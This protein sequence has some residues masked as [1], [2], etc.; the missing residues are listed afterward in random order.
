MRLTLQEALKRENNN[1]NI[2]RL[3]ASIAVIFGH[4]WAVFY[5]NGNAEPV[6]EIL[7]VDFSASL[8]V[9]AFFFLSGIFI[10]SSFDNSKS[11]IRF[12]LMRIFRIYPGLIICILIT[13]FLVGPKFST[14]STPAYFTDTQ[15]WKYLFKNMI[16]LRFEPT[17]TGIFTNNKYSNS[18]NASLWSL[19]L[20]IKCYLLVFIIGISGLRKKKFANLLVF[21]GLICI[22][23]FNPDIVLDSFKPLL[24]FSLGMTTYSFKN[25]IAIDLR[26]WIGMVVL[27]IVAFFV[28]ATL[29][30]DLFYVTF[31]YSILVAGTSVIAKGIK[32]PGDF[33]Y[34]IYIYGFLV[35]QITA[36]F[37]PEIT[38]YYS[39]LITMPISCL[40]GALSWYLIES[41][42]MDSGK[43][44]S[45]LNL[46]S[47][48]P[49]SAN[50]SS[51]N[52]I[53]PLL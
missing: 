25:N 47:R 10:T 4:S 7:K 50:V 24:F 42:A 32:L 36:H 14:L 12:V 13:V 22:Y 46:W 41:P 52:H 29:F 16:M 45:K 30:L 40:I 17:L 1:F 43:R 31:A 3:S 6:K 49:F 15:T 18:V 27:S 20:E 21:L 2:V 28:N 33:S 48:K 34:G 26:I 37:L 38:V 19:P 9:Y 39:M 51:N 5:S 11:W 35:Q 44:I 23:K 8:A 53:G